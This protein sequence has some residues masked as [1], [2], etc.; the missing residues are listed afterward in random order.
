M[1]ISWKLVPNFYTFLKFF[2]AQCGGMLNTFVY[3]LS[4]L[5]IFECSVQCNTNM[6]ECTL[7]TIVTFN[8][9]MLFINLI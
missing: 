6:F 9:I 5:A 7:L 3:M 4:T 2:P 1:N 8:L